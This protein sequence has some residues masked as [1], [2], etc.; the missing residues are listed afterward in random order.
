MGFKSTF[1]SIQ[2]GHPVMFFSE[3]NRASTQSACERFH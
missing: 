1:P 2:D 3:E